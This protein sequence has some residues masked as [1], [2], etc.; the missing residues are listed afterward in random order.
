MM[1]IRFHRA[2]S[3]ARRDRAAL[4]ALGALSG[5]SDE[6]TVPQIRRAV[7]RLVRLLDAA[8]DEGHALQ[9]SAIVAEAVALE[10][11]ARL[12]I[13]NLRRVA[14]TARRVAIVVA[15]RGVTWSS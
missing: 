12:P 9:P 11:T 4:R 8:F 5:V 6:W 7:G 2:P 15:E 1:L 10:E 14:R 13:K 3:A